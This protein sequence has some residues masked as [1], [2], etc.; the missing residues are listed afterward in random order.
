M[1]V[2]LIQTFILYIDITELVSCHLAFTKRGHTHP[3]NNDGYFTKILVVLIW[4]GTYS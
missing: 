3:L 2:N 4:E 1:C